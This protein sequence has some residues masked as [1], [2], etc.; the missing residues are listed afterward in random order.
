MTVESVC[1]QS[2]CLAPSSSN[3]KSSRPIEALIADILENIAHGVMLINTQGRQIYANA[4]A[5]GINQQLIAT[6]SESEGVAAVIWNACLAFVEICD[7]PQ[8]PALMREAI[9]QTPSCA[10]LMIR[11]KWLSLSSLA[12]PLLLVML[13][14]Q[15]HTAQQTAQV[16]A[17]CYRL[18]PRETEVWLL[19]SQG[20][21]YQQI[22]KKLYIG[23]NTVKRHLKSIYAK[24]EIADKI[25]P[26]DGLSLDR[27]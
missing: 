11:V 2:V 16:E 19:R 18:T 27:N 9:L 23:V 22:A 5:H 8:T 25:M 3:G 17:K 1:S 20:L 14:D 7:R 6:E 26:P 24:R 12:E 4:Y 13:E 21:R 15:R 10:C